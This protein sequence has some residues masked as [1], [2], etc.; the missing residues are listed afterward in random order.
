MKKP[1]NCVSCF[2]KILY[3]PEDYAPQ[4]TYAFLGGPFEEAA[5]LVALFVDAEFVVDEG[6]E[7]AGCFGMA[8]VLHLSAQDVATVEEGGKGAFVLW[9]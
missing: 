7:L 1:Q 3:R 9:L 6:V 5:H 4:A 2:W 8:F